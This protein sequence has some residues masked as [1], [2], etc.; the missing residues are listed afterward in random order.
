MNQRGFPWAPKPQEDLAV[1]RSTTPQPGPKTGT[2]T[3]QRG[4]LQVKKILREAQQILINEGYAGLTIR[5]VAKQ[6][7]ISL[8]NLTYYFPTKDRLLQALIA[9]LLDEYHSA[10]LAEQE[11][12]PDDPHGRFLAYL[13]YLIADCRK[14]DTRATF[15]QIWGLATHNDVVHELR[16][17]IYSAFRADAA[18]LLRPLNPTMSESEL[19]TLVGTLIALIE[20]LHVIFDLSD[21]TLELPA[22]FEGKFR[23]IVYGLM[24]RPPDSD[25]DR[26]IDGH[27]PAA[28]R[29]F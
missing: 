6:L 24:T 25:L 10:L 9:D 5:K 2:A 15:F 20:G 8:G 21:E 26:E 28:M 27:L 19:N 7:N 3:R 18:E 1:M 22:D 23:N 11:R 14:A 4:R 16:H 12:F 17:Q 29:K 13:E